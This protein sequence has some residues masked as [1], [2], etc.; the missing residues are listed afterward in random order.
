MQTRGWCGG[1]GT[2]P[3][4]SPSFIDPLSPASYTSARKPRG[5]HLDRISSM[6][7]LILPF[8]GIMPAIA[9]EHLVDAADKVGSI[10]ACV[11]EYRA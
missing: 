6:H 9:G 10:I 8:E 4:R 5:A 1:F 3:A 7:G 2:G 11:M